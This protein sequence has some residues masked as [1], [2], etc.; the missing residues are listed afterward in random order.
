MTNTT[1][2]TTVNANETVIEAVIVPVAEMTEKPKP[3]VIVEGSTIIVPEGEVLNTAAIKTAVENSKKEIAAAKQTG[4]EAG[5]NWWTVA[6]TGL[7]AGISV[8]A[9]MA[10]QNTIH[11]EQKS[12]LNIV[13]RTSVA[14]VAAAGISA[15]VQKVKVSDNEV[16]NLCTA[17]VIANGVS[18]VDA[19]FGD[20]AQGM[21]MAGTEQAKEGISS[22]FTTEEEA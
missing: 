9:R 21:F 4:G 22:M 19:F 1:S 20:A 11:E 3:E 14:V 17:S 8:G 12:V 7:A 15:V 18:L 13:T 5:I 2:K 10:I 6:A 16:V